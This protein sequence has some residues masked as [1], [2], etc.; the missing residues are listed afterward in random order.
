MTVILLTLLLLCSLPILLVVLFRHTLSE[1]KE[2]RLLE[3]LKKLNALGLPVVRSKGGA[4]GISK[5]VSTVYS[6]QFLFPPAL[7]LALLYLPGFV[8]CLATLGKHPDWVFP[9]DL[10]PSAKPIAFAFT[11]VYLF[12]LGSMVRRLYLSD[13]TE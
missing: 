9:S 7:V 8:L 6:L 5:D 13:L 11:G 1:R 12:N 4:K 10:L 2:E 3:D